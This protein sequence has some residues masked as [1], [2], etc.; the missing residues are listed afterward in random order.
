MAATNINTAYVIDY[1][2]RTDDRAELV[3]DVEDLSMTYRL[4]QAC[5]GSR[6]KLFFIFLAVF[7]VTVVAIVVPVY[8]V[9]TRGKSVSRRMG[10]F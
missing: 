6:K 3:E 9:L 2:P 7:I 1:P 10:G 8:I 4:R 5:C